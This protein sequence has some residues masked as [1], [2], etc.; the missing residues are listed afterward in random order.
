MDVLIGQV[1]SPVGRQRSLAGELIEAEQVGNAR[2]GAI[3]RDVDEL[4]RAR[5][6]GERRTVVIVLEDRVKV[7]WVCFCFA[8][9]S[10]VSNGSGSSWRRP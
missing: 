8:R 5:V 7:T 10:G 9:S 3:R 1:V 4:E 6:R 2:D